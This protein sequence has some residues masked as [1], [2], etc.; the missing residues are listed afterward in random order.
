MGGPRQLAAPVKACRSGSRG[1]ERLARR[2]PAGPALVA[3]GGIRNANDV[4]AALNAGASA[5]QVH[6]AFTQHGP[7]CLSDLSP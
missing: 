6:R 4:H 5:V 1:L 7:A 3:V 2:H